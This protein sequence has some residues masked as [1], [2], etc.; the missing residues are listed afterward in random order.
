MSIKIAGQDNHEM[1]WH[2]RH[3]NCH[4]QTH[5]LLLPRW[6]EEQFPF[7]LWAAKSSALLGKRKFYTRRYLYWRLVWLFSFIEQKKKKRVYDAAHSF[8][9]VGFVVVM[10]EELTFLLQNCFL[11][12]NFRLNEKKKNWVILDVWG[13]KVEMELSLSYLLEFWKMSIKFL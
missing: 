13:V 5:L 12:R 4:W 7:L 10:C 2:Q 9:F 8:L 3:T 1:E 11:K 6:W